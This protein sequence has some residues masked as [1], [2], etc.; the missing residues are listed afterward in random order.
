MKYKVLSGVHR[1]GKK[2]YTKGMVIQTDVR[3]DNKFPHK[4]ERVMEFDQDHPD[5]LK[6][7]DGDKKVKA[8][9]FEAKHKGAGKWIVVNKTSPNEN[10][11]N[12]GY[13]EKEEARKMA[14]DMN[15]G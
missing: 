11:V 3:L 10:Q 8:P 12:E 13:L 14:E 9:E 15:C 6:L 5:G 1:V 4:F 2:S 7:E